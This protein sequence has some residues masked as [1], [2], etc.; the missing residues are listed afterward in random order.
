MRYHSA[1]L[2]AKIVSVN[3]NSMGKTVTYPDGRRLGTKSKCY[4]G[5]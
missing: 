5:E 2:G 3:S 1:R 4:H